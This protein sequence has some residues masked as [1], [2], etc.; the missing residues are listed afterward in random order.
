MTYLH[1]DL[2]LDNI[3][4]DEHGVAKVYYYVISYFYFYFMIN[5]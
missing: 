5:K 3:L 4:L 1:R 2:K